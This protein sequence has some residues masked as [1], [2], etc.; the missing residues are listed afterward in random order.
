MFDIEYKGGNTLVIS[1]KKTTLV[2]DPKRSILG[3]KDIC[4]E[5]AVE[6]ATESRFM[7]KNDSAKLQVNCPGEFGVGDVEIKGVAARLNIAADDA[8]LDGVIYRITNSDVSLGI[9]GNI[10]EKLTEEQLEAIGIID[11]LVLPVG[12]N[13]LTLDAHSA[14][15]LVKDIDP[16]I[17]IPI[18]YDDPKLKYE[19]TQDSLEP[20]EKELGAP[21]EALNKYKVKSSASLPV[22][23]TLV[24][25]DLS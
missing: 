23:L 16:K 12:G 21:K 25:L 10:Y 8:P 4:I 17:V 2:I 5:G 1:T 9:L 13:G 11:I 6:L 20:F 24:E 3:L 19:I 15:R 7:I 22:N 18:H 14:A